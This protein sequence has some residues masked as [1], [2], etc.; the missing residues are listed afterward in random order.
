MT[1]I[2]LPSEIANDSAQI[3]A[4]FGSENDQITAGQPIL[5][6]DTPTDTWTLS[7]DKNMVISSITPRHTTLSKDSILGSFRG[8]SNATQIGY[9]ASRFNIAMPAVLKSIHSVDSYVAPKSKF[10]VLVD[11]SGKSFDLTH[12]RNEPAYIKS[13]LP[14]GTL[15]KGNERVAVL[16]Y[17]DTR[18]FALSSQ[19]EYPL[20]V[21]SIECAEHAIA[22]VDDCLAMLTTVSGQALR[23][24]VPATGI[25]TQL[26]IQ[27]GERITEPK[28]F[29]EIGTRPV[30]ERLTGADFRWL[31]EAKSPVRGT[32]PSPSP[33]PSPSPQRS[34]NTNTNTN[35]KKEAKDK[36]QAAPNGKAA[37][38]RESRATKPHTNS[39]NENASNHKDKTPAR[40]ITFSHLFW[41]L[42]FG[43]A[44]SS[45]AWWAMWYEEGAPPGWQS[46]PVFLAILLFLLWLGAFL[47]K[48]IER[49][50]YPST[51]KSWLL[52]V[53]L[54][55]AF[56]IY[57]SMTWSRALEGVLL[58]CLLGLSVW[59][60]TRQIA[61]RPFLSLATLLSIFGLFFWKTSAP[62]P[63]APQ[64]FEDHLARTKAIDVGQ[65][66]RINPTEREISIEDR[67]VS[68]L[69]QQAD[70]LLTDAV[71]AGERLYALL[72]SPSSLPEGTRVVSQ[73]L[74]P[75]KEQKKQPKVEFSVLYETKKRGAGFLRLPGEFRVL[76]E[77]RFPDKNTLT[78]TP[79]A[80]GNTQAVAAVLRDSSRI[81]SDNNGHGFTL[82]ES[83]GKPARLFY[84][85]GPTTD[86]LISAPFVSS[87]QDD[88]TPNKAFILEVNKSSKGAIVAWV[89]DSERGEAWI[90]VKSVSVQQNK[91]DGHELADRII[92]FKTP[93]SIDRFEIY[94]IKATPRGLLVA[95]NV[96][97]TK[98]DATSDN[99][100]QER[101]VYLAS[102]GFDGKAIWQ[103]LYNN[104]YPPFGGAFQSLTQADKF[105]G[106]WV[107]PVHK[108]GSDSGFCTFTTSNPCE[109]LRRFDSRY[110]ELDLIASS[111]DS[112]AFIG[113]QR[114]SVKNR[115]ALPGT[116]DSRL[117]V[118]IFVP[119]FIA[120]K[121]DA[122]YAL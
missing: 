82:F 56:A 30:E 94:S 97:E 1:S 59:Y 121:K 50:D 25:V 40:H 48:G 21:T 107:L 92:K 106:R 114:I 108:D 43:F 53:G 65:A 34:T 52:S 20:T 9:D 37:K 99:A 60:G 122:L 45:S 69:Q 104:Y 84:Y 57:L 39:K 95:A 73:A 76:W 80:I 7:C 33:S 13:A 19:L 24:K 41:G 66:R 6:V 23:L 15:I 100:Q 109:Y 101:S 115:S 64:T 28:S 119:G 36:Q 78:V 87:E 44:A 35:A 75:T 12:S 63:F 22:T 90:S 79:F 103:A 113:R 32:D 47:G 93:A 18:K 105:G 70:W 71:I 83:N 96:R 110:F 98:R 2:Y 58:C 3:T 16:E 111:S 89:N 91:N 31:M 62:L 27:E 85:A 26:L 4:V 14:E 54:I 88:L 8:L 38:T 10:G 116:L 49:K 46:D 67:M 86:D 55:G 120:V 29:V 11:A 74:A 118:D 72:R 117:N 5:I 61:P 112:L 81:Q 51:S 77:E 42:L 102:I 68:F 17:L